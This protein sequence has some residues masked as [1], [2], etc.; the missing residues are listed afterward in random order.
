MTRTMPFK[1]AK[2]ILYAA[3]LAAGLIASPA[4]TQNAGAQSAPAAT[5][6]KAGAKAKK[7]PTAGQLAARER[8]KKCGAEWKAAKAAGKIDKGQKWPQYW[9]ACN[10]RLKGTA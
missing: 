6:S 9:S 8:A 5:E 2:R 4:L 7:P 3:I 10:K 1:S